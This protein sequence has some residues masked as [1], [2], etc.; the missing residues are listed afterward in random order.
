MFPPEIVVM[1]LIFGLAALASTLL[2][3]PVRRVALRMGALDRPGGRRSHPQPTP[4]LGGIAIL[5]GAALASG[6]ALGILPASEGW[7]KA[8]D[9]GVAFGAALVLMAAGFVDDVRG[10][11]W[12][13]KMAIQVAVI[14]LAVVG[15]GGI[16]TVDFGL[17]PLPSWAWVLSLAFTVFWILT[18]ANAVNLV[19]GLDGLAAGIGLMAA[20]SLGIIGLLF[21]NGAAAAALF[22]LGGALGGFWVHNRHPAS[23]FMG[24]TG[25]MPV[26][27]LLGMLGVL[28]AEGAH[29]W[30]FLPVGIALGVPLADVTLSVARRAL[31]PWRVIRVFEEERAGFRWV[32]LDSPGIFSADRRHL[33]HRLLDLGMGYGGTVRLLVGAGALLG[34]LSVIAALE[35]RLAPWIAV[36]ATVLVGT[37]AVH[38]LYEELDIVNRGTLLP[39]PDAGWVRRFRIRT[40]H[41][42][43][44]IAAAPMLALLLLGAQRGAAGTRPFLPSM[45]EP[46]SAMTVAGLALA[47]AVVLGS[48]LLAGGF[49]RAGLRHAGLVDTAGWGGLVFTAALA[50]GW[51]VPWILVPTSLPRAY[52]FL[53]ALLVTAPLVGSRWAF[54]WLQHRHMR[55]REGVRAAIIYG[56]GR[57]GRSI[58]EAARREPSLPFGPVGFLDDDPALAG[59][60][61]DGLPVYGG[62][63]N[64]ERAARETEAEAVVLAVSRLPEARRKSLETSCAA[65]GWAL[66][67]RDALLRSSFPSLAEG[68]DR[69]G[70]IMPGNVPAACPLASD[71]AGN[72]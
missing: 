10:L 55:R 58:L 19:D 1:L 3:I 65:S 63:E 30:A 22:A 46:M 8:G 24:D 47:G 57:R 26:G 68:T 41:D 9:I 12:R 60:I 39:L 11:P 40:L 6:L 17:G 44:I 29:G 20:A 53:F 25:A 69:S 13:P 56:A 31:G 2:V 42:A 50:T 7:G 27:F 54:R 34:I 21:G 71:R 67:S 52:P 28:A 23:I 15:V 70:P 5:G 32:R 66:V 48:L 64:L 62:L 4:V 49:H 37:L 33:H 14:T 35:P 38:L 59:R 61:V 51:L 72:P 45:P 36:G 16:P 18:T 43:M